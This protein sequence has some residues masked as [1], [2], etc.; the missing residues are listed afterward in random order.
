MV[1]SFSGVILIS[2]VDLNIS[3]RSF[4]GDLAALVSAAL[5]AMYMMAGS[6]A[7]Q[8]LETTSYTTICYFVCAITA[9]PV[10]FFG[11]FNFW[12]FT[13]QQWWIVLGLI[14]GAQILGHTMFNS[15]LKRV[16]PAVVSLIIFFEV[17]VSSVLAMWW[18]DQTPPIG[19]LPGIILI[20]TGCALVVLRTRTTRIELAP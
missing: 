8:T 6:K 1:V 17:P 20:L 11:G 18:L 9:L 16:S 5:A 13:A 15:A 14:L 7:Q 19:I 10:V 2:G 12:N 4:V 3:F